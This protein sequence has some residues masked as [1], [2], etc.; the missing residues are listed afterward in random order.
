MKHSIL[1]NVL[2]VVSLLLMGGCINNDDIHD[3]RG[4]K[5]VPLV[6]EDVVVKNI[7]GGAV[8]KYKLDHSASNIRYVKAEVKDAEGGTSYFHS[9]FGADSVV[10]DGLLSTGKY[11]VKLYSV[12]YSEVASNAV[13]VEVAPEAAPIETAQITELRAAFSSVRVM[14]DNPTKE[15]LFIGLVKKIKGHWQQMGMP[16]ANQEKGSVYIQNQKAEEAEYGAYFYDKWGH[17][18]KMIQAVLTPLA[19]Y[20]VDKSLMQACEFKTDAV[21]REDGGKPEKMWD[22]ITNNKA[23][24][25]LFW[26]W[27]NVPSWI[28]IDLGKSYILSSFTIWNR[29]DLPYTHGSPRI[30]E[31]WGSNNPNEDEVVLPSGQ[32]QIMDP[33]WFFIGRFETTKPSGNTDWK[34]SGELASDVAYANAGFHFLIPPEYETDIPG[35]QAVRYIRLYVHTTWETPL[36]SMRVAELSFWGIPVNQ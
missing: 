17:R 30:F 22:G 6:P 36:S 5:T 27:I 4:D 11:Q 7:A 20:P 14:Y 25:A 9:S 21:S 33:S 28:S 23:V 10:I 1:K 32:Q 19:E 15:Q 35:S 31:I 34:L 18:S 12:S 26:P 29:Y 16:Y 8:V 13:P 2:W 24:S 3:A